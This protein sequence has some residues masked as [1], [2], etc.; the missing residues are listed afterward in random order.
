MCVLQVNC[1]Y[2]G[3]GITRG[4]A[5]VVSRAW[6]TQAWGRESFLNT[7]RACCDPAR[8]RSNYTAQRLLKLAADGHRVRF[9]RGAAMGDLALDS[10]MMSSGGNAIHGAVA[11]CE[12]VS[13]FAHGLYSE[14]VHAWKRYV[15]YYDASDGVPQCVS[16]ARSRAALGRNSQP[17][18]RSLL[19]SRD[20]LLRQNQW[21]GRWIKDRVRTEL[22]LHV[23]HALGVV[24]WV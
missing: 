5:C 14:H 11:M 10:T 3:H 21:V 12:A 16:A 2:A 1:L 6:W 17:P 9:V 24:D 19:T 8:V 20:E 15:H 7:R 18:N 23:L 4:E 22:L 13:L